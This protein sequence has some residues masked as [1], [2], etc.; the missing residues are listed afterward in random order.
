MS[1]NGQDEKPKR[2]QRQR[3]GVAVAL[4]IENA[5]LGPTLNIM[6]CDLANTADAEEFLQDKGKVGDSYAIIQIKRSGI[7]VEVEEVRKAR[8][9]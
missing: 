8:L 6:A 2:K 7:R 4:E 3:G 5:E 9:V 1:D